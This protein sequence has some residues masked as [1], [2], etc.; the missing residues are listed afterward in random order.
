MLDMT[1]SQRATRSRPSAS[2]SVSASMRAATDE[3]HIYFSEIDIAAK[4]KETNLQWVRRNCIRCVWHVVLIRIVCFASYLTSS[5]TSSSGYGSVDPLPAADASTLSRTASMSTRTRLRTKK[6]EVIVGNVCVEFVISRSTVPMSL[7]TQQFRFR[8]NGVQPLKDNSDLETIA[9]TAMTTATAT[10]AGVEPTSAVTDLVRAESNVTKTES[11]AIV[12]AEND[13]VFLDDDDDDD[14]PIAMSYSKIMRYSIA[15]VAAPLA[16]EENIY[17]DVQCVD[18][19]SYEKLL[20]VPA[21]RLAESMES[22]PSKGSPSR[23]KK[24]QAPPPPLPPSVPISILSASIESI[25]SNASQPLS[26]AA[27]HEKSR[28]NILHLIPDMLRKWCRG[29]VDIMWWISRR[30]AHLIR[31]TVPQHTQFLNI[32]CYPEVRDETAWNRDRPICRPSRA[33]FV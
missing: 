7:P 9:E 5:D 11:A 25:V 8:I 6:S 19:S 2:R 14:D 3:D 18:R 15:P 20:L 16:C 10:V 22:L 4:T 33:R 1:R 13:A 32:V 29:G 23:P 30:H 28:K 17:E 26:A 27:S 21:N 12:A 24:R 31:R